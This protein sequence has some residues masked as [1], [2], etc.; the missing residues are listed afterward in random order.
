MKTG[1]FGPGLLTLSNTT[2]ETCALI[3]G[4]LIPEISA[5]ALFR[6]VNFWESRD[7]SASYRVFFFSRLRLS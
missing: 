1:E 5:R 3:N 4:G 2:V 6:V 7:F